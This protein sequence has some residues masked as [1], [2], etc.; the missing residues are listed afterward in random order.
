MTNNDIKGK[1]DK[2]MTKKFGFCVLFFFLFTVGC[3][4][5]NEYGERQKDEEEISHKGEIKLW[6]FDSDENSKMSND[7]SN[8]LTGKG[9]LCGVIRTITIIILQEPTLLR[10]IIGFTRLLMVIEFRW[11]LLI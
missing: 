11:I 9:G 7:F 4:G 5:G 2:K 1:E 10:T 8:Q 3:G 6:N